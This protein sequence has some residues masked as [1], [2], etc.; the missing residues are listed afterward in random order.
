MGALLQVC[1]Q[2]SYAGTLARKILGDNHPFGRVSR[3]W[4]KT[5]GEGLDYADELRP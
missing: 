5:G 4:I 3:I 1:G 2:N